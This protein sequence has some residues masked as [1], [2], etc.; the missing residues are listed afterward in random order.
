MI[1]FCNVL[2]VIA[3]NKIIARYPAEGGKGNQN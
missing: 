1:V 2:I 3:I